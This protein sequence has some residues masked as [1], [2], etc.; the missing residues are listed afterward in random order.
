MIMN[1]MIPLKWMIM[2]DSLTLTLA[3]RREPLTTYLGTLRTWVCGT[4]VT[5]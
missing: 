3:R 4:K 2:Y 5:V 1:L